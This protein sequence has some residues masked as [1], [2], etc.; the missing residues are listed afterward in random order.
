MI[1]TINIS[2]FASGSWPDSIGDT[3]LFYS[4]AYSHHASGLSGLFLDNP[5]VLSPKHASLVW[6]YYADVDKYIV[7]HVQGSHVVSRALG[8]IYPFR[9]GYEVSRD[10]MNAIGVNITSLIQAVPRIDAMPEGRVALAT[11]VEVKETIPSEKALTLAT[12]VKAALLQGKTLYVALDNVGEQYFCDG[13]FSKELQVLTEAVDSMPVDLRR[14][15]SFGFCVDEHFADVLEGVLVVVYDKASQMVPPDDA[16]SV[17]WEQA[18]ATPAKLGNKE[19]KLLQTIILP[20]KKEPL[21]TREQL[22]RA[23]KIVAM[24]VEQLREG[25][26]T[27]WRALGNGFDLLD[28]KGWDAFRRYYKQMD[29][30]TK[31]AYAKWAHTPSLEWTL[32]G[33][34]EDVF[35]LMQYKDDEVVGLQKKALSGY[36]KERRHS[37]LFRKGMSDEV[38]Q[39]LDGKFVKS[40]QFGNPQ[41]IIDWYEIFK[42]HECHENNGVQA[43]FGELFGQFVVPKLN[44]MK[45]V[46]ECMKKYPFVPTKYFNPPKDVAIP[47]DFKSLKPAYRQLIEKWVSEAAQDYSFA[48]IGA[49]LKA[50]YRVLDASSKEGRS[51][52]QVALEKVEEK[53]LTSLLAGGKAP[54]V[55]NNSERL[56]EVARDLPRAWDDFVRYTLLPSVQHALV[57]G[58]KGQTGQPLL[59]KE[60]LL[61]VSKWLEIAKL[62]ETHPLVFKVVEKRLKTL[63]ED[64]STQKMGKDIKEH[65]IHSKSLERE[66]KKKDEEKDG[67]TIKYKN[68]AEE[69]YPIIRLYISTIKKTNKKMSNEL[70]HLFRD[71]RKKTRNWKFWGLIVGTAVICAFGGLMSGKYLFAKAPA[72]QSSDIAIVWKGDK[73]S[74]LMTQLACLAEW[75]SISNVK[76][77]TFE[78]SH[79]KLEKTSDLKPLSDAY[80]SMTSAVVDSAMVTACRVNEKGE[81]D[82]KKDSLNVDEVN[83][84]ISL[85]CNNPYR[86][87]DVKV[88]DTVITIPN[89]KILGKDSTLKSTMDAK[90][91]LSVV[92]YL[93]KALPEDVNFAY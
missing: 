54:E 82:E 61:D 76:V 9:A 81:L 73:T 60:T 14:Y 22:T 15:A 48:D 83:P 24:P 46:V 25:D 90:Y 12:Y 72:Q 35:N 7:I 55:L 32:E 26:W 45:K 27:I 40:L 51:P 74:N 21:L 79:L 88:K 2:K 84:L 56:L 75:D 37:F 5:P 47:D 67:K 78:V 34:H 89:D 59:S 64:A 43:A 93:S 1:K 8:R 41:S 31:E 39:M 44:S 77:D 28:T 42:R 23:F 3:T 62:K 38:K 33:F 52:E 71:L 10:E 50:F 86:L 69:A 30:A 65:F 6:R 16:L 63:F 70:D 4:E 85:V 17:T 87:M 18:L 57:G 80:Y 29:S 49:L 19:E 91:Y 53:E 11:D 58:K 20:G 36:L 66:K 13:V 92:K 68:K